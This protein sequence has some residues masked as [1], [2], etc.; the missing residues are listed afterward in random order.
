MNST[1]HTWTRVDGYLTFY[2]KSLVF[3][4]SLFRLKPHTGAHHG[5][6]QTLPTLFFVIKLNTEI[7]NFDILPSAPLCDMKYDSEVLLKWQSTVISHCLEAKSTHYQSQTVHS[8]SHILCPCTSASR[9]RRQY[10]FGLS[11]PTVGKSDSHD[12]LGIH[13][14]SGTFCHKHP[15]GLGGLD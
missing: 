1:H 6:S 12:I 15:L 11:Y 7:N 10:V 5:L 13:C 14:P 4:P 9:D 3:F 8:A 2:Q